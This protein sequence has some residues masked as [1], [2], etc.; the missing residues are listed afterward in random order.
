MRA[1]LRTGAPERPVLSFGGCRN[2]EQGEGSQGKSVLEWAPALGAE[3]FRAVAPERKDEI[4][5]MKVSI[6]EDCSTDPS[7]TE[8]YP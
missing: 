2:P 5:C 1:A 7:L 6:P 3:I 4:E 8:R